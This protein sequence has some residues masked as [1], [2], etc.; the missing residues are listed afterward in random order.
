MAPH[1]QF[2]ASLASHD[3]KLHTGHRASFDDVPV[4]HLIVVQPSGQGLKHSNT[5]ESLRSADTD[6]GCY[7]Q[8]LQQAVVDKMRGPRG[9]PSPPVTFGDVEVHDFD[10]P[11]DMLVN[12]EQPATE[13]N[14]RSDDD[15]ERGD[16]ITL[17]AL[18]LAV[19][20][21]RIVKNRA[22]LISL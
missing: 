6:M 1:Q 18:L 8:H 15:V 3:G 4:Q 11:P 12:A 14:C 9:P 19:V 17:D 20:D 21:K 2:H 7:S 10:V 22:C 5:V 13:D 16:S